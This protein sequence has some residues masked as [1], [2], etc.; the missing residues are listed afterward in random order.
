MITTLDKLS[1]RLT[2]LVKLNCVHRSGVRAQATR[3]VGA[4]LG[5]RRPESSS[6]TLGQP[7]RPTA[8]RFVEQSKAEAAWAALE[9]IAGGLRL[10]SRFNGQSPRPNRMF[11]R[12]YM[13]LQVKVLK[14][15]IAGEPTGFTMEQ[16]S[17]SQWQ[18]RQLARRR[19]GSARCRQKPRNGAACGRDAQHDDR[20]AMLAAALLLTTGMMLLVSRRV[21][22]R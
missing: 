9:E 7:L 1:A 14:A 16:W 22:G 2:R 20:L 3:L 4:L 18:E 8:G 5:R 11:R 21:T 12:Q 13:A 19:R 15:L 6:P 17:P 10:P